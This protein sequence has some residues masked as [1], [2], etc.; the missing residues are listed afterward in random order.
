MGAPNAESRANC[1][2][3]F[4]T[5]PAPNAD[6][7]ANSFFWISSHTCPLIWS[8]DIAPLENDYSIFCLKWGALNYYFYCSRCDMWNSWASPACRFILYTDSSAISAIHCQIKFS[9]WIYTSQFNL[10]SHERYIEQYS[11]T[12]CLKLIRFLC[13]Q[14]FFETERTPFYQNNFSIWVST[15]KF[16]LAYHER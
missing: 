14:I 11:L 6:S 4:W 7:R 1:Y 5:R 16:N 15:S 12:C 8:M 13:S 9:F 2:F 3:E 10:L